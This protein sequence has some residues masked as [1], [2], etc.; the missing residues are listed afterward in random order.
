[1]TQAGISGLRASASRTPIPPPD[2]GNCYFS[3]ETGRWSSWNLYR[4][5]AGKYVGEKIAHTQWQG[6]QDHHQVAVLAD[7]AEVIDFFGVNK[8][9]K[10]IF[11]NAGIECVE[12]I[13]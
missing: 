3:G 11:E 4:T 9:G 1:M 7:E 10:E 5:K 2:Q 13:E 6:E 8:L 12:E